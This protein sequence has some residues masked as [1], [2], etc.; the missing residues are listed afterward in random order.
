[1]ADKY[2]LGLGSRSVFLRETSVEFVEFVGIFVVENAETFV[3]FDGE[4]VTQGVD[5]G[6]GFDASLRSRAG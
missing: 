2:D 1:V 5:P 3:V 6:G 4:A